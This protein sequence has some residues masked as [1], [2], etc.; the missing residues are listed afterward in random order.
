[1]K[2]AYKNMKIEYLIVEKSYIISDIKR[3]VYSY[4][5]DIYAFIGY[6][7]QELG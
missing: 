5:G 4:W 3:L 6:I 7:F 2:P 1:M